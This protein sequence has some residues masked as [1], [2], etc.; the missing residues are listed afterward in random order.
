MEKLRQNRLRRCRDITVHGRTHIRDLHYSTHLKLASWVKIV[1]RKTCPTLTLLSSNGQHL[2]DTTMIFQ[3]QK[4]LKDI[5]C[6]DIA[7][8]QKEHKC[9]ISWNESAASSYG[10]CKFFFPKLKSKTL[11]CCHQRS[12]SLPDTPDEFRFGLGFRRSLCLD[13]C[14]PTKRTNACTHAHSRFASPTP[15]KLASWVKTGKPW[16]ES[17]FSF[18]TYF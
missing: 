7:A 2:L 17:I 6:N 14:Q 4:Q 11:R 9:K 10:A 8:I 1:K 16:N 13:T 18:L 3:I 5:K 12:S 15:H